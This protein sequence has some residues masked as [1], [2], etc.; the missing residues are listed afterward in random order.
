[1]SLSPEGQ[2]IFNK[3]CQELS[4]DGFKRLS[5]TSFYQVVSRIRVSLVDN[6]LFVEQN[7]KCYSI[8]P[9]AQ[10]SALSSGMEPILFKLKLLLIY[11]LRSEM[12]RVSSLL[13]QIFLN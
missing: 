6:A 8:I 10:W 12:E 2:I 1:M 5:E 9:E 4:M 11:G 7:G 3:L 13:S